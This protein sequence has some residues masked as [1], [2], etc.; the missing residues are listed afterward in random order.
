LIVTRH[1]LFKSIDELDLSRFG[2]LPMRGG[3]AAIEQAG[4]G[5]DI[6]ARA[7]ACDADTALS[8]YRKD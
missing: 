2:P 8:L 1:F 6:G 4:F 7:D 3:T 5:E